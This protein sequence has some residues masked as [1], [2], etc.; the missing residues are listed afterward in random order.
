MDAQ[1]I[2][3]IM[4]GVNGTLAIDRA[5]DHRLFNAS[6]FALLCLVN[7]LIARAS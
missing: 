4:V 2:A 3:L 1:T 6:V 5:L 7:A